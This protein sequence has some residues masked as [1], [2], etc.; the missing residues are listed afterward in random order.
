L[1]EIFVLDIK[2]DIKLEENICRIKMDIEQQIKQFREL[3]AGIKIKNFLI[4]SLSKRYANIDDRISYYN[5]A[6]Q[7][8][9]PASA[10]LKVADN[11]G[12]KYRDLHL[13]KK[14][15]TDGIFGV[16]YKTIS[17]ENSLV[18]LVS[19]VMPSA[20]K[21]NIN[22]VRVNKFVT[23]LVKRKISKHF[24]MCHQVYEVDHPDHLDKPDKK[25]K[26]YLVVNEVAQGDLKA[27]TTDIRF[28]SD[29]DVLF[30]ICVQCLLSVANIHSYGFIHCDCH[31]G[32]FLYHKRECKEG[33][34]HYQVYGKDYYLKDCGYNMMIYDFGLIRKNDESGLC[35]SL[36]IEDYRRVLPIFMLSEDKVHVDNAYGV[37]KSTNKAL[38]PL[39]K[40]FQTLNYNLFK[41]IKTDEKRKKEKFVAEYVMTELAKFA[42]SSGMQR[43]LMDSRPVGA[44]ILN[45]GKP[46]IIT[47]DLSKE[48]KKIIPRVLK[49]KLGK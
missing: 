44:P 9:K 12:F 20:I 10:F 38:K 30:N 32:N 25:K 36:G 17:T 41:D 28:T 26:H 42:T 33:Y 11:E 39:S 47:D 40:F 1:F 24:L 29:K 14:M 45:E 19:K 4:K 6:H 43:I 22:E 37:I 46:F 16:I 13:V 8:V 23:E 15:G 35:E 5:F 21:E 2:N 18:N 49:T 7:F 34:Y 48:V 3:R 27:L 31:Y